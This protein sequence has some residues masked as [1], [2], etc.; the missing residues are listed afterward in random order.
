MD[1]DA[2]AD[3]L[4]RCRDSTAQSVMANSSSRSSVMVL[5]AKIAIA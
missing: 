4:Q 5:G 3:A 2:V 1:A